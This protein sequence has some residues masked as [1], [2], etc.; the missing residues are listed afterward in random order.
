MTEPQTKPIPTHTLGN[1][2]C[3]QLA[4]GCWWKAVPIQPEAHV[5]ND[6]RGP[7]AEPISLTDAPTAF[8]AQFAAGAWPQIR[9]AYVDTGRVLVAFRHMPLNIHPLAFK[10]AEAAACAQRKGK[11]WEMHDLAFGNP[12]ALDD[13][14]LK[15]NAAILGLDPTEFA[16]CLGGEEKATVQRDLAEAEALGLRG[17][18]T[19]FVGPVGEDGRVKVRALC[20]TGNRCSA[21]SGSPANASSLTSGASS[22]AHSDRSASMTSTRAARAAGTTDARTAAPARRIAAPTMGSTPGMCTS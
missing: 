10:A 2:R 21:L 22:V 17:T 3:Q 11:F 7:P 13:S 18:P 12:R 14:G 15:K 1:G 20:S 4:E 19:F 5:G 8:C 16:N 6:K 9:S